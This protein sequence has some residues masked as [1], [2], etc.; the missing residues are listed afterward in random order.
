MIIFRAF[1]LDIIEIAVTNISLTS[2]KKEREL[3]E[4]GY[5]DPDELAKKIAELY[6]LE[7]G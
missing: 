5:G 7:S 6:G 3:I 2:K 4:K 1:C